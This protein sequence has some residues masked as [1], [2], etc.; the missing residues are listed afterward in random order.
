MKRFLVFLVV[1]AV[2]LAGVYVWTHRR[3]TPGGRSPFTPATQPVLDLSNVHVLSAID[4]ENESVVDKVLPS[5]VS[6]TTSKKV[7]TGTY[8]FD[9]YHGLSPQ[10]ADLSVLGSGVI[11]SKE[12]HILTNYH[13][14]ADTEKVQVDLNDGRVVPAEVLGGD[15]ETDIAVLKIKADHL[16]P[17]HLGD[18]DDVKVG[19]AVFAV[20]NPLGL[21]ETV[22]HGIISAKSRVV[23]ESHQEY[24]QTDAA[25]NEGNSGGPLVNLQ[26]EII[27]INTRVASPQ[28]NHLQPQ[29][30]SFAIPSNVAR[31]TM[32]SIINYHRVVRSYLGVNVDRL[33]P[34]MA[35]QLGVNSASAVVMD[36]KSGSP[37]EGAGIKKGDVITKF[38]NREIAGPLDLYNRVAE[39]PVDT[40]VPIAVVRADGKTVNLSAKIIERPADFQSTAASILS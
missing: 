13:V 17:L 24:F 15:P 26:G 1:V 40:V 37:A 7:E 4:Q 8:I 20:G 25:I 2:F 23:E 11:V 18:S 5:V 39:T 28:A 6:I 38:N 22:T 35:A 10:L 14:V 30:L 12:G 21:Q 29:G 36:V 31:R 32:E 9:P 27:G 16:T 3:V 33:P 34:D 19:Q